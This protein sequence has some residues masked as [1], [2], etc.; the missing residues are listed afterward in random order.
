[1]KLLNKV[2]QQKVLSVTVMLFTLSI[3]IVIGTLVNSGVNAAR[4]QGA[5]PDATPL[6]VP[7]AAEIGNEFTKLAKKLDASV[8]Y[9]TADYMAK[10]P[11]SRGRGRMQPQPDDEDSDGV[12]DQLRRFFGS[13]RGGVG[14]ENLPPQAL[15]RVQSGTGFIVDKNGYIITNNHV[16]ANVDHIKVR[17]HG[18][19]TDYRARLIGTDKETDLAVIKIDPKQPLTPV[20]IGNSDA[21]QVGDWSVA[22]GSPFGLEATVTAGIVSATGRNIEGAE[23]F[24]HFIQT[25]AAINRGNSGGP[26]L[27]I[28]GEV[29]GINTMIATES[30]GSQGVGFAL[31]VNMAVRVYNDIIRDGRVT[32]G[33]I[34]VRWDRNPKPEVLKAMGFSGG[35]LVRDVKKDGPADKAGLQAEDVIIALNG[36]PVKD[37]DDLMAR[38]ADTPVGNSVML[39]VDRDGKAQTFKLTIQDR[40]QVFA[41]EEQ[42]VGSRRQREDPAKP[43]VEPGKFGIG[44][45]PASDQEKSATGAKH[46]VVVTRVESSSFA[47]DI[48]LAEKDVITSINRKPVSSK[49]DIVAIQKTLKAGDPVVFRVVRQLGPRNIQTASGSRYDTQYLSGT[50]PEN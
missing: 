37:G 28:R 32:R 8:V 12:P 41:D 9:I 27:N 14:P 42:V 47:D 33:S 11:T 31:P 50:L 24:Q 23:Q 2:R 6:V 26:L 1:M 15:K 46:G 21:V 7:K 18:D 29:I 45:R 38:V 44:V 17:L 39:T 36:K 48:G 34:G 3:G 22:I 4:G 25:D 49:E 20:V 40:T 30:G 10:A 13:P 5:A 35:V 19:T 16:V 43:E